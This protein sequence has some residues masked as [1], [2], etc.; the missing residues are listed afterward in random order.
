MGKM[1]LF[2]GDDTMVLSLKI[3]TKNSR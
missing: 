1:G 2:P 3:R